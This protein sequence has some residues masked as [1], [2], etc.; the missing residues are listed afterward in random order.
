[1]ISAMHEP[2]MEFIPGFL[3]PNRLGVRYVLGLKV[4]ATPLL[5]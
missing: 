4:R 2:G 3:M 1:M 5:Q